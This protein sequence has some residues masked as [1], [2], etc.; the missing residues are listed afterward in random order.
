MSA[1]LNLPSRPNSVTETGFEL[2]FLANS[3]LKTMFSRGVLLGQEIADALKLPFANIV[4][5]ALNSLRRD[6]LI[7]VSGSTGIGES[8]YR[9]VITREGRARARELMEQNQYV[10]PMPVT[11]NAYNKMVKAQSLAGHEIT[12]DTLKRA[13]AHL[14]LS[15]DIINQLGPAIN[16]G[17]SVFLFGNTGDGKTS[18]GLATE[19][20]LPG[21]IWVPYAICVDGQIIKVF[22]ALR[23]HT[24]SE[25]IPGIATTSEPKGLLSHLVREQTADDPSMSEIRNRKTYDERWVLIHRPLIVGGGELTLKNLDLVFDPT[26]KIHEAPHQMK[27]NGGVFLVDDLGRQQ[28]SPREILSRWIVPLEKRVDYLTF[29]T[30]Q[31]IDVPF[32]ALIIFATNLDPRQVSD[33]AFL[34]R[35]RYK[36]HITDPTWDEFREIFKREAEKRTLAYSEETFEYLIAEYY[37]KP[38]REPR[39]VHPRDILD[40]LVDIAHFRGMPPT[41]SKELVD[42]ACQSYFLKG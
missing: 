17:K 26:L 25:K 34:R 19:T 5:S 18:I 24:I 40:G 37:I 28:N 29:A 20:L 33:E 38:K 7:E 13:L 15:D 27:A 2:G 10:G 42:R 39:G 8:A 6:R 21:A 35:L 41:L 23:H 30:G 31:K 4:G 16:A 1:V 3:A 36:I 32:D 11:L 22:D 9:Y 14:V 12:R